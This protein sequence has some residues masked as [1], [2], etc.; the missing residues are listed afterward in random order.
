MRALA[1]EEE[2]LTTS[3]VDGA[4]TGEMHSVLCVPSPLLGPSSWQAFAGALTDRGMTVAVADLRHAFS[5]EPPAWPEMVRLA[6]RAARPLPGD[7]VIVGHSGA[8]A[9][10]PGVGAALGRRLARLVFVDAILPPA[11]GVHRYPEQIRSLVAGLAADGQL[12]PWLDW[13]PPDTVTAMLP[14]PSQVTLLRSDMTGTP[15]S[16]F[17]EE[18]PVPIAWTEGDALYLRLSPAYDEEVER[19]RALGWPTTS[20]DSHHLGILTDP[21]MVADA[22]F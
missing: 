19:A 2:T 16:W 13:W 7:V 11:T 15:E 8:G 6:R 10:L 18:I 9:L 3:A 12:P 17:D 1:H 21:E 5:V 14:D 22:V 4:H 20:L